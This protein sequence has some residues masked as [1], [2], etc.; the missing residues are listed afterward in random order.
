MLCLAVQKYL[1]APYNTSSSPVS[2]NP[3]V[4]YKT[5]RRTD[6]IRGCPTARE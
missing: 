3:N 6:A 5:V 2:C 4:L 1:Y